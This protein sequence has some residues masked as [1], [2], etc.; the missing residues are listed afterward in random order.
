M[1]A[2]EHL[3][4]LLQVPL[5]LKIFSDALPKL[6]QQAKDLTQLNRFTLY[7]SFM[8][9]WFERNRARL[10]Q[11][12]GQLLSPTQCQQFLRYSQD[13]AF[14]LFKAER[15]QVDYAPGEAPWD[16]FFSQS[17]EADDSVAQQLSLT[18]SGQSIQFHPQ[19][20]L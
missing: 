17:D 12:L 7:D 18:P 2:S 16:Q 19:I 20:L 10:S 8:Q 4:E 6:Q 14:A 9:H 15:V 3:Q 5:M 13:L 11:N 1:A